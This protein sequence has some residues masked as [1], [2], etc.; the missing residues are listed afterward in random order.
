MSLA[1]EKLSP[2]ALR[3]ER[4]GIGRLIASSFQERPFP[5]RG[6]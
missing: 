2:L 3:R 1:R 4:G 6:P 5:L